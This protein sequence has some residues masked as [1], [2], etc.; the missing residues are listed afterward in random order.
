MAK[1]NM[2]EETVSVEETVEDTPIQDIELEQLTK[3]LEEANKKYMYLA[4][5]YDNYRKRTSKEREAT[6]SDAV[7]E[8]ILNLLTF[9]DDFGR[10][11]DSPCTDESY[12]AGI[13][14]VAKNLAAFL[15]NCGVEEIDT[16]CEFNPEF[17]N[18]VMHEQDESKP[19]NFISEVFQKGYKIKGKVIRPAMVKVSN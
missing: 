16:T 14:M 5:E 12:K 6:Y 10:A 11:M 4:A 1:E 13:N 18:A 7:A 19:E 2:T 15:A 3:E 8:T 17:H 9:I